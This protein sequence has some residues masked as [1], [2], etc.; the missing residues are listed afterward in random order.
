LK[1]LSSF[2]VRLRCTG[3]PWEIAPGDV[4]ALITA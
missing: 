3:P 1:A 2:S 4:A